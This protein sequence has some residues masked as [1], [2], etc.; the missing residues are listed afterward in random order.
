MDEYA[1]RIL[2]A[3]SEA[4]EI[5]V[6]GSF[7]KGT[8]GPGSDIDVVVLLQSSEKPMRERIPDFLPGRFPVG[9]DVFPVTVEELAALPSPRL[10]LEIEESPWRYRREDETP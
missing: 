7:V 10:R 8:Y 3:H 1:Q 6:F 2:D 9:M 4:E 5:I